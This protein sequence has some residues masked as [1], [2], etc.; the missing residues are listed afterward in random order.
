MFSLSAFTGI[1]IGLGSFLIIGLLHPVVIKGEYYFGTKIWPLFLIGG[2]ICVVGSILIGNLIV[3][4]LL[5][6]LG[7]SL[8][9]SIHELFEQ[10]ERVR[11]GWF[12]EN[13]KR[14]IK[15]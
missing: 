5:G 10:K 14:K 12:P 9:W 7:F 11:K 13:P 2:I 4:T 1:I 6:V 15:H 3:S 8:F